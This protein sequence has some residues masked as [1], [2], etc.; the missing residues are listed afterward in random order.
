MRIGSTILRPGNEL[1]LGGGRYRF[2]AGS[3]LSEAVGPANSGGATRAWGGSPVTNLMPALVEVTPAGP[4]QR[5]TLTRPEYWLGR[6]AT[7]LIARPDDLLVNPRHARL[8]CDADGHW[9][10]ENNKSL[11]GLWLRVEPTLPLQGTCQFRLGE[12]RFVF[13]VLR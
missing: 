6:D 10:V 5:H 7:C 3:N 8:H 11:N 9:R 4:E 12:Q 2:E 1:I 13:K